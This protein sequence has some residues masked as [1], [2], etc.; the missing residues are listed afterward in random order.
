M[1]MNKAARPLGSSRHPLVYLVAL[2]LIFPIFLFSFTPS[3][4]EAQSP[5]E[6]PGDFDGDCDVDRDDLNI[7]L[8]DRNK[9][10]EESECG[11]PCDLDQDGTITVLDA[12]KLVLLC[13]LPRCAVQQSVCLDDPVPTPDVVGLAQAYAEAAI[14]AAN[15]TVGAVSTANSETVPA[16]DVI[17]QNPAPGTLV[18]PGSAVDIV[19][20]LGP[21]PIPVPDVV[22]LPQADAEAAIL[23]AN[24]TVGAV[25][26]ANSETI[27]EGDVIS[28]DPAPGTLA[29]PGS[30][31]DIV[32]SLGPAPVPVPDVVALAQA[33]AEAAIVAA[34][35]TVGT[36]TT[37]N[38]ETVLAGDVISQDPA[39]GALVS[40]GSAVD[41]VVSLGPASVK[42]P[43]VVGL[44]QA[45]AE[46]AIVAAGLTVGSV[47][48]ANSETVPAGDVISQNPVPG[49]FVTPGSPVDLV[50][51]LG[52]ALVTVPDVLG[53]PNGAAQA[54]VR[55][56]GLLV[57][58]VRQNSDT[59]ESGDVIDQDPAPGSTVAAQSIVE[60]I[61][62][63]GAAAQEPVPLSFQVDPT[64]VPSRDSVPVL[65]DGVPRPVAALVDELGNQMD[66]VENELALITGDPAE[67][68]GLLARWGGEVLSQ[69]PIA[70]ALPEL[71]SLNMY[72]IRIDPSS[73]DP[74]DLV[75]NVRLL[76]SIGQGVHRVSSDAGLRLLVAASEEA[77][78]GLI[79]ATNM[80]IQGHLF[81][82]GKTEE[83]EEYW[84][85]TPEYSPNAFDWTYMRKG[86][87]QDIGVAQAWQALEEYGKLDNKVQYLVID[88]GFASEINS[89]QDNEDFPP[90]F[91]VY[92]SRN[93]GVE[94]PTDCSGGFSCPW[95]GTHVVGSGMGVPDNEYGTAGPAG[96][97][98]EGHFVAAP[99]DAVSYITYLWDFIVNALTEGP[100]IINMSGG[101]DIPAVACAHV[102][103]LLDLTTALFEKSGTMLFA[104]AGNHN[105]DVDKKD[106]IRIL[107]KEI[108]WEVSATVPCELWGVICVG[109][110]EHDS[111]RRAKSP[112]PG[113]GSGSNFG[114]EPDD[115]STVD[116]FGPYWVWQGPNPRSFN[117]DAR[118]GAGTSHS[119][120]FVAGIAALVMAADPSLGPGEVEDILMDTAHPSFLDDTVP[121]WVDAY[122]AVCSRLP[123]CAPF[124]SIIDP[125]DG[126][127]FLEGEEVLLITFVS[128]AEDPSLVPDVVWTSDV[129]GPLG[130]GRSIIR[131]D[132]S[133]GL[134]TITADV[135]DSGGKTDSDFI[136][137]TI[138][139]DDDRDGLGNGD[140]I[141]HGTD[142][143]DPDSDDDG[144]LDGE[145]VD[146]GTDPLDRDTDDDGL[147]DGVEVN[148]FD[149]LPLEPDSDGDEVEDGAEA[150][151]GSSPTDVDSSPSEV[152]PGAVFAAGNALHIR[153]MVL[154]P[155]T[156]GY[157]LL[158]SPNSGLGFGLAFDKNGTLFITRGFDLATYRLI[159][160][161]TE[162]IGPFG[163]P[164]GNQIG[165]ITL[166]F[167]PADNELYGVELG[168]APD[169]LQTGQLVRID[170]ATGE[171]ER[172]GVAGP[173][174]INALTF[175]RDGVLY[176]ALE[177]PTA[178]SCGGPASDCLVELDPTTGSVV[179]EIGPI[180]ATPVFGMAVTRDGMLLGSNFLSGDETQMLDI[181]PM[182]GIGSPLA[183]I[184]RSVFDLTVAPCPAPC[185]EASAN[186]PFGIPAVDVA[187]GNLNGDLDP[188]I[189]AAQNFPSGGQVLIGDGTGDFSVM[190]EL[191]LPFSGEVQVVVGSL[192]VDTDALADVVLTRSNKVYVYLN[193]G[194]GGLIEAANSPFS[195]GFTTV[196]DV[197]IAD[198]T[199]DGDPDI[200]LT[201][202]SGGSGFLWVIPGDGLGDFDD[203][204]PLLSAVGGGANAMAIGSLNADVDSFPD[205]VTSNGNDGSATVVL[206]DGTGSPLSTITIENEDL[207]FYPRDVAVGDLNPGV[208]TF[209]DLAVVDGEGSSVLVA[210]G[211]GAGNFTLESFPLDPEEEDFF[212]PKSVA[213]GDVTHDGLPDIVVANDFG[214]DPGESLTILVGDGE[215][216]FHPSANS[217]FALDNPPF[218]V[219]LVDVDLDGA[220]D[221]ILATQ[222]AT[223]GVEVFLNRR[224]F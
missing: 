91:S 81:E 93:D 138:L 109:G 69:T 43:D 198:L 64:V 111:T 26:T 39:P 96:P 12:R 162:V 4:A 170:R 53:M 169:L 65:D 30:A 153:A 185:L 110:L 218:A 132:L 210:L 199:E 102:C 14:V 20:S 63:M 188:D 57:S 136:T 179:A 206:N 72:H 2:L 182:T 76:T 88:G 32:V 158:E 87:G 195:V 168:P 184:D 215:G 222:T 90:V 79:V 8:A 117:P 18:P 71:G 77:V 161:E 19:V 156:G 44:A 46:A 85:T 154:D 137:L 37:I 11:L 118:F 139:P 49:A 171:G 98:A 121:R 112:V 60:I 205:V 133:L 66:F 107:G 192:D 181:D 113:E 211:D 33:D 173:D 174:P 142:P 128:D 92:P 124:L 150:L 209:Q 38:S 17:S 94:N 166:A 208:D 52:P 80:V 67:L 22:A 217:P 203:T 3:V 13:T 58:L 147:F 141:L 134:H 28:Q 135:A 99:P 35:L 176:A 148:V 193:D 83:A 48:T 189:A 10:V 105:K 125:A 7:L 70:P 129:D 31:V 106:R 5:Q 204:N 86:P 212:A 126:A 84:D 213:I 187:S 6:V 21:A 97:V 40:P 180:G 224:P 165:A 201:T 144:L 127:T 202:V 164:G 219:E 200:A 155:M 45:G 47:T 41:I 223:G 15:L 24:L 191:L 146:I 115:N 216:D 100:D 36:I 163:S 178:S 68:A 29:P 197:A 116:I 119:S 175:T 101:F 25:S 51:S 16:G 61:V 196:Q 177:G 140:E 122:R 95:H 9:V 55:A 190:P 152:T 220:L 56:E 194:A 186:S 89:I 34:N 59:V 214:S 78:N 149:S 172:V 131:D 123:N 108:E 1:N 151:M 82:D 50:V 73:A 23:A 75:T 167:N 120:P 159:D 160:D 145:E 207:L 27:P 143:T 54:I 104:S 183:T 130:M 62:S 74:A 157:G 221:V 42:V 114:G 103:P